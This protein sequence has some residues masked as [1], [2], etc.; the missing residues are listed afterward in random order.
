MPGMTMTSAV[1]ESRAGVEL[2]AGI[3]P[4]FLLSETVRSK[5]RHEEHMG[6]ASAMIELGKKV[7]PAGVAFGG[8]MVERSGDGWFE[9]MV[10]Y[11]T[12][13]GNNRR[14][15]FATVVYGSHSTGADADAFANYEM[16]R[17]GAEATVD[18][19][20]TPRNRWAQLHISGG[21]SLTGVRATGQYCVDQHG[22][23][24]ECRRQNVPIAGRIEGVHPSVFG[25]ISIDAGR[26]NSAAV[27]FHHIRVGLHGAWGSQ[28]RLRFG[29]QQDETA[30]WSSFGINLSGGFG[31]RR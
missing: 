25:G 20:A 4:G 16:S 30:P 28:P 23:G 7:L 22:Y 12:H 19:R 2:Q 1:P 13:I 17:G 11:R 6:Q 21:A 10:R 18:V 26:N 24:L 31:A 8:R 5:P 27:A 14:F 9:P 3:I 15:S 29:R